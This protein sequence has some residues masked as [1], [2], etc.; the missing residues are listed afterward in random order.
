MGVR[1][2]RLR[3]TQAICTHSSSE[4]PEE[5][6]GMRIRGWARSKGL[7]GNKDAR[8]FGRNTYP[9]D[10]PKPKALEFV[11]RLMRVR[12]K[13]EL[14]FTLFSGRLLLRLQQLFFE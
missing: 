7:T 13:I 2:E 5:D 3:R 9:T 8:L 10:K 11:D 6:A 14:A 1:L 4:S 12:V